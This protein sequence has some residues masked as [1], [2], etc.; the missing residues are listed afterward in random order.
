MT[1]ESGRDTPAPNG[2]ELWPIAINP[3]TV[4][5]DLARSKPISE[6]IPSLREI[7]QNHFSRLER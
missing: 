5:L 1:C 7:K 3:R 2:E 6:L 4:T